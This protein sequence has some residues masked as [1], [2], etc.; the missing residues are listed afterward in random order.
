MTESEHFDVPEH[1]LR[2]ED[3]ALWHAPASMIFEFFENAD[4][5]L[6]V[7]EESTD[8]RLVVLETWLL[9]D[10]GLRLFLLG[11]LSL[12][13]VN[14]PKYD[15]KQNLLPWSFEPLLRLIERIR[16]VNQALPVAPRDRVEF[17]IDFLLWL[18][19][20]HRDFIDR[21]SELETQFLRTHDPEALPP[22]EREPPDYMTVEWPPPDTRRVDGLWLDRATRIDDSWASRARQLNKARNLAAHSHDRAAIAAALGFSGSNS[23]ALTREHCIT[24]V[25]ELLGIMRSPEDVT[26]NDSA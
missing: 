2:V 24:L 3:D 23:T 26:D 21:F 20:K 19:K 22:L 8:V 13:Q 18:R 17:P 10:Y 7:I 16:D 6:R 15:L 25:R 1:G 14:H 11:G 5:S 9:L 12:H 4:A